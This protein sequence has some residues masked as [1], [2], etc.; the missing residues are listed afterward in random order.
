MLR[1][2]GFAAALTIATAA[3]AAFV[4]PYPTIDEFL[5]PQIVTDTTVDG[6]PTTESATV[7]GRLGN[8]SFDRT[9]SVNKAIGSTGTASRVYSGTGYLQLQNTGDAG[10]FFTLE[11]DIDPLFDRY[12]GEDIALLGGT[13]DFQIGTSGGVIIYLN[14]DPL[15]SFAFQRGQ[16]FTVDLNDPLESGNVLRLLFTGSTGF[17]GDF[18][19]LLA[20]IGTET[21]VSEP[22]T[23]GLL[24]LGVLSLAARRRR[25]S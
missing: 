15:A 3:N 22:A 6:T 13:A 23:L 16:Y 4:T 11:Y 21:P 10:A 14:D 24:G 25:R 2:L 5:T 1:L 18:Y 8:L 12:A 20:V 9:I 7:V 17:S 19:P